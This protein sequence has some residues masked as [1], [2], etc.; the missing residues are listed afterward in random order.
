MLAQVESVTK[1][2]LI[3]V[4]QVEKLDIT[5]TELNI[6]IEELNRTIV[7]I[8]SHKTRLSQENIELVKEVQD[9]KVNL[10]NAIYLKSQLAGQLEDARRRAEDDERRRSLLEANLHQVEVELESVR[11]QLEE[12]SEARLDLER[13]LVKSQGKY[14]ATKLILYLIRL[15][16]ILYNLFL[17]FVLVCILIMNDHFWKIINCYIWCGNNLITIH[18]GP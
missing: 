12:E 1:E 17:I 9:I 16:W 13:Q 15:C 18:Q 5:I 11:I 3:A 2:R 8:T 14:N 4:K 10:E 7:D 6:R